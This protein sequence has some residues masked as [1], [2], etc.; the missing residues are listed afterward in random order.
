MNGEDYKDVLIHASE[1]QID[2]KLA[3]NVPDD[4]KCYWMVS[5]TPR[6]TRYGQRVWFETDGRIVAVGQ[7]HNIETGRIWFT[8]LER[9]DAEP[10][11]DPPN[12]GFMY[13]DTDDRPDV[14]VPA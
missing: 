4:H 9:V 7:V 14:E 10:P 12:Q 2:H 3:E 11:E 6:Q 8:P 5:G 1:E 13:L